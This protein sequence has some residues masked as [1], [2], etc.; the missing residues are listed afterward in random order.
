MPVKEEKKLRRFKVLQGQH[1]EQ[2]I[3][4]EDDGKTPR[5]TGQGD[6]IYDHKVFNPGDVVETDQDLN[7]FNRSATSPKFQELTGAVAARPQLAKVA[8]AK[9]GDTLE[10]MSEEDL[11]AEAAAEEID[12]SKCK[13]KTEMVAVIRKHFGK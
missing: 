10:S 13:N 6:V 12:I 9:E 11:R 1:W 4:M 7:K 2:Y 3:L 5:K 8:G